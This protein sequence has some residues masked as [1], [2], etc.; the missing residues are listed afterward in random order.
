MGISMEIHRVAL[1][2]TVSRSNWNLEMLFFVEWGKLR[3][4]LEYTE[5]NPWSK[6]ENQ[7]QQQTQPAKLFDFTKT[8]SAGNNLVF[9]VIVHGTSRYH[10]N[11]IYFDRHVFPNLEFYCF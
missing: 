4:K 11:H 10:S 5:K 6:D 9:Y 1:L 7:N 2:S 3:G 8:L